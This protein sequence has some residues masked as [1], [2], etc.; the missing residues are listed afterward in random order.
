[1]R[2]ASDLYDLR[3]LRRMSARHRTLRVIPVLSGERRPGTEYGPLPHVLARHLRHTDYDAYVAGPAGMIRATVDV[4]TAL[5]VPA[6]RIR[7]DPVETD[8]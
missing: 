5:G 6:M 4:L 2:R 3:S 1:V 7:H 8:R